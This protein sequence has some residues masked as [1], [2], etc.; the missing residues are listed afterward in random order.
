VPVEECKVD[1]IRPWLPDGPL[2][3]GI[4]GHVLVT[5]R[6]SG[7]G[8]L[9]QVLELDVLDLPSA[10]TLLRTRVPGLE[11]DAGQLPEVGSAVATRRSRR[12]GTLVRPGEFGGRYVCELLVS[13]AD[14]SAL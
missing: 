14:S 13:L 7:F 9:G 6:R 5:T 10:I 11:Q 8:S 2:P 1:D 4:P 3:P 12:C